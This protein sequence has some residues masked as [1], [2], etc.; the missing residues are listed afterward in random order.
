MKA[1]PLKLYNTASRKKEVF[2]PLKTI[3]G[4]Y[5]CGPTV[6]W[7]Q[8]IGNMRTYL[9]VDALKRTLLFNKYKV[10]HVMN[11]TDVGHLT[12]DSDS[13]DD[14]MELAARKEGKSA[15]DI[16]AHYLEAFK[17]DMKALH[18][19]EPNIWCKATDH[20]KEQIELIKKLEK[21]RY[22][23]KT[24]D[25][26]YFNSSKFKRYA[27]FAQLKLQELEAGKRVSMGNK[28]HPSDFALWKFSE[29][30]GKRQQEWDA[31]WGVGYP[32]WHIEC[33]AMSMKYLGE[34]FDIHTG[35]EDHIP[36][37]HTNEIAQSEAATSKHF[38][39][40][41]LHG[42]FLLAEGEKVSKSKG[43]LYTI[44]ELEERGIE[45]EAYRYLCLQTHYRKPLNFTL[46]ALDGAQNAYKK[47]IRA[48][49]ILKKH[50]IKG[51]DKTSEY[52]KRFT[53]AV[54]DDLMM[55]RALEV[56]WTMLSDQTFDS[57]KKYVL[58]I[59]FDQVLGL[60]LKHAAIPQ[61]IPIS[62]RK[63]V[64]EREKARANKEWKQADIL[65]LEIT[66]QGYTVEDTSQ[67]PMVHKI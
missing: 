30:P 34:E 35:G 6:Y 4:L 7:Y 49:I 15:K 9:F 44:A 47:L 28:Q 31:P 57:K 40:Y 51:T 3:V 48:T 29:E 59:E 11:V 50:P 23:Y 21:K 42:A 36:V 16:A 37:H 12:N 62:V 41:W 53:E 33:S 52:T 13:G 63:L 46:E 25:G 1:I 5:S 38:A 32:G 66:K 17:R 2:K 20:I 43:G 60:N 10:K 58:L 27:E 26:I 24:S 67:G 22:T 54:N 8:H 19:L 56:I 55:P 45:P 18:I 14:K 61:E 39:H 64:A 65:R